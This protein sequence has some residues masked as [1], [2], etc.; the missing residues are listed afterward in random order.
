MG[1]PQRVS[2]LIVSFNTCQLTLE[3]IGSV[4]GES[5]VEVIVVDNASHD[6]SASAIATRFPSVRLIRSEIN[7]GFARGV[8]HAAQ[9]ARG[10]ALLVL[11]SDARMEP[12]ALQRLL[13]LLS[14]RST[15]FP[16]VA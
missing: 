6:D 10:A 15:T 3:A 13:D 8:N 9:S 11:N 7:L 14:P 12:G 5:W 1:E 16:L 4:V 2:V